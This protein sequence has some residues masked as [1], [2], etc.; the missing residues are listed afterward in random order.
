MAYRDVDVILNPDGLA[1]TVLDF[2]ASPRVYLV[3]YSRLDDNGIR[4]NYALV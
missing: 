1:T 2:M 3:Y 4:Y